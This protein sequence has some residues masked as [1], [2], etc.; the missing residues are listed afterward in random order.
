MVV[1]RHG[2]DSF[3]S[4]LANHVLIKG[5]LDFVGLGQGFSAGVPGVFLHFLAD[6]VITQIHA[7]VA[8][9]D[10]GP[11]NQL[12]DLMLA[13]ATKRAVQQLAVVALASGVGH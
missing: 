1:Y 7:F 11:R 10:R 6:D 8:D 5:F 4:L 13:F 12:A 2:E 3:G 9:K